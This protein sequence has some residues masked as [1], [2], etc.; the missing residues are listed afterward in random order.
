MIQAVIFDW[1]G[2][3]MKDF[4]YPGPMVHWPKVEWVD[5]ME[6]VLKKVCWKYL[7]AI[8]SNAGDSD[9]ALMVEAL[10]RIQAEE[11]FHSYYTSKDLGVEKPHP[12]FFL[13]I[14]QRLKA[15]PQHCV[16]VGNDYQKDIIGA[17]AV[18]MKTVFYNP[19]QISGNYPDADFQLSCMCSL[20]KV[21]EIIDQL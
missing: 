5:E 21:L 4:G 12:G 20:P 6:D 7:C 1:G 11:Y 17:K 2:T 9:T 16:M 3:V 18:G 8:A 19:Q 14:C 13:E 10:E 15:E